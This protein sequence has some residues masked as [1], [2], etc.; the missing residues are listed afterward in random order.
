LFGNI[1]GNYDLGFS[2]STRYLFDGDFI[3]LANISLSYDVNAQLLSR[4]H[5]SGLKM[6]IQGYNLKSWTK[7]KGQDPESASGGY[8]SPVYP[9]QRTFSAGINLRF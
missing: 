3:R 4:V 9:L 8:A 6:Y 2:N 5:L 1:N 7:F